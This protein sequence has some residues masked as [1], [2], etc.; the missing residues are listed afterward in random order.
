MLGLVTGMQLTF[1]AMASAAYMEPDNSSGLILTK[2]ESSWL[3]KPILIAKTVYIIHIGVYRVGLLGA[4]HPPF[5]FA[6]RCRIGCKKIVFLYLFI[7]AT[8]PHSYL[9]M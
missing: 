7:R 8:L 3:G 4:L 6:P 5:I 9:M 2:S 1:V